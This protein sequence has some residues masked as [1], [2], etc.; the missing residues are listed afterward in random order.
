[1][2]ARRGDLE[3]GPVNETSLVA[4]LIKS[5]GVI[6]GAVMMAAILWRMFGA[7]A[8]EAEKERQSH[9]E[10]VRE[11]TASLEL[12]TGN[13]LAAHERTRGSVELLRDQVSEAKQAIA[14]HA[15]AD[16]QDHQLFREAI[17]DLRVEIDG[18]PKP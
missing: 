18:K 11:V 15:E 14:A 9:R 16:R 6:A 3:G 1:M 13:L 7:F 10:R 5:G 12:T 4:E 17:R 8:G 2:A